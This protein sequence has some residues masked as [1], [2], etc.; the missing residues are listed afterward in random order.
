MNKLS[1]KHLIFFLIACIPLSVKTYTSLFIY[2]GGK[3]SW[4][5]S[6]IASIIIAAYFYFIISTCEKYNC[7]NL[8]DIYRLALGKTLGNIAICL[9]CICLFIIAVESLA[10]ESNAI[11]TNVFLQTPIWYC[12][13]FFLVPCIYVIKKEFHTILGITLL[14]TSFS[15]LFEVVLIFLS[16]KYIDITYL[17]PVWPIHFNYNFIKCII[18]LVGGFSEG[19]IALPYLKFLS[20]DKSIKKNSLIGIILGLQFAVLSII[21][22]ISSFGVSRSA[23]I[24]YPNLIL[25]ERIQYGNFF[26][27]GEAFSLFTLVLGSMLKY[28]LCIYGI[29]ILLKD[30]LKANY[31]NIIII[32][33]LTFGFAYYIAKNTYFLFSYLSLILYTLCILGIIIPLIIF[34]IYRTKSV[35]K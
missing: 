3:D 33:A 10:V 14:I 19:I 25:S 18:L 7:Y 35:K 34:M 23:N 17:F 8:C 30:K 32:G 29:L 6:I 24:F 5:C 1:T 12:L 31:P 11:H 21:G 9:Y 2:I 20:D 22:C 4:V 13:L 15:I 26:E 27:S 16:S 28:I